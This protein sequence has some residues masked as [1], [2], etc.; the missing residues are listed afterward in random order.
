M[1]TTQSSATAYDTVVTKS[2]RREKLH[3]LRYAYIKLHRAA[4]EIERAHL[5]LEPVTDERSEAMRC[6]REDAMFQRKLIWDEIERLDG[7]INT[8]VHRLN[9]GVYNG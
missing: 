1:Q 6:I 5:A 4:L 3:A 8:L 9:N 7:E 2:D